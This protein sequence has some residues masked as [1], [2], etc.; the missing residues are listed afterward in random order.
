MT[1][2]AIV[3]WPDVAPTEQCWY[4]EGCVTNGGVDRLDVPIGTVERKGFR[5]ETNDAAL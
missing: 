2:G 5:R 1:E 3:L 4:R